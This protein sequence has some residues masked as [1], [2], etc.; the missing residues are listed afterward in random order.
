MPTQALLDGIVL[1][2]HPESD[3]SSYSAPD[4]PPVRYT[5]T[6]YLYYYLSSG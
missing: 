6:N 3:F 4:P 1:S 5:W 2:D